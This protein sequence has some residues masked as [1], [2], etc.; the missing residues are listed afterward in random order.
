MWPKEIK[1]DREFL[2]DGS[3]AYNLRYAEVGE[4]GRI[5]HSLSV[6]VRTT[7]PCKSNLNPFKPL[8]HALALKCRWIK[9][10]SMPFNHGV[11]LWM[12]GVGH[13]LQKVLITRPATNV[14]RWASVGALDAVRH[15]RT[16]NSG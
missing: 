6:S 2:R 1:A 14:F 10:I 13:R 9:S 16:D 7:P 15:L 5:L 11:M 3:V 12:I 4:L 8:I